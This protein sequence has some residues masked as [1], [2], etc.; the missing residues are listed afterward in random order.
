MKRKS[1]HLVETKVYQAT[2]ITSIRVA[3]CTRNKLNALI[4]LGEAVNVDTLIDILLE[5]YI[6]ANL[7]KDEKKTFNL[8]FDI[9]QKRD[10]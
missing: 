3:K 5:E 4:Q 9:I 8:I 1:I 7:V 2:N 6:E 10:R